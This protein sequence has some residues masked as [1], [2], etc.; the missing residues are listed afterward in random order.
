LP[1]SA[2]M[3]CESEE[4]LSKGQ[5]GFFKFYVLTYFKEFAR[6]VPEF[7]TQVSH[8]PLYWRLSTPWIPVAIQG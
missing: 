7:E 6:Y 5:V 8:P 1:Q 4:Q 3:R 2:F